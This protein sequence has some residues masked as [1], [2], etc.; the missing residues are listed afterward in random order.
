M[1]ILENTEAN[2]TAELQKTFPCKH[3]NAIKEISTASHEQYLLSTDESQAF[4]WDM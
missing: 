1:P 2:Y 3:V 4:F